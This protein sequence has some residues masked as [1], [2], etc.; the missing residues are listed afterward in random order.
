[1][2]K[3]DSPFLF[4]GNNL[5]IDFTNTVIVKN[6]EVVDLLANGV[7]L[8]QWT[9]DAGLSVDTKRFSPTDFSTVLKLRAAIQK[10]IDAMMN[11][12]P[13]PRSALATINQHL[14]QFS[15]QQVLRYKDNEYILQPAQTKLTADG[16]LSRLAQEAADLLSSPQAR[17]IKRCSNKDCILT[18]VDTSRSHK[19]RW[20]SMDTCGNRSKVA[21][22]YR[23]T[24]S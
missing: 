24:T 12:S 8:A 15:S 3:D 13:S 7:D 21:T 4:I 6:G 19:R 20:C 14:A 5:A 11:D 2:K 9:H 1:M 23:K 18:F 16:L 22:H 17:Q 10:I